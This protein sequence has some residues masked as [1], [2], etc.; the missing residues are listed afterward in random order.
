MTTRTDT[1]HAYFAHVPGRLLADLRSATGPVLTFVETD[2]QLHVNQTAVD[3]LRQ[4]AK[5]P[6]SAPVTAPPILFVPNRSSLPS[7]GCQQGA[8]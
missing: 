6:D 8:A 3:T 4:R 5:R 2:G 1:E 7:T